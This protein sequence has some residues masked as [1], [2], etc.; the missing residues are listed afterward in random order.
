MKRKQTALNISVVASAL[1][2]ASFAFAETPFT[3]CPTQAFLIQNPTGT[4]VAYGV[5]IDVGSYVILDSN[6]DTAKLNGVG[7]SKHDDFIYGWDYGT[8]SLSRIDS[9]FTKTLLNVSKPSG[10][11]TS[12][13]VGDVSLDENAWY[14]YRPNYGLYK[15]DLDTLVMELSSPPSQFGNPAIYDLAFH[16]DNSLAYSIDSNGYL[17][18]IDVNANSDG[19]SLQGQFGFPKSPFVSS[20]GYPVLEFAGGEVGMPRRRLGVDACMTAL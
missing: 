19:I 9:T 6:L 4:P 16:P 5:N 10:A 13:Y 8:A 3:S 20:R 15:I 7:Y 1:F 17:W 12:I 2:Q 11:P 14:G 18:E